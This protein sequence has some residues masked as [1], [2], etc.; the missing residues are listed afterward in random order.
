[1]KQRNFLSI[2]QILDMYAAILSLE[3]S[4]EHL[5]SYLMLTVSMK[6]S[7]QFLHFN[8]FLF[9]LVLRRD[10][11]DSLSSSLL[12]VDDRNLSP[13]SISWIGKIQQPVTV[14]HAMITLAGYRA[15][16]LLFPSG[17]FRVAV[18]WVVENATDVEKDIIGGGILFQQRRISRICIRN[19]FFLT[20][21]SVWH[22]VRNWNADIWMPSSSYSDNNILTEILNNSIEFCNV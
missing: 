2:Y 13:L 15:L 8:L 22:Q 12:S 21:S 16:C 19:S 17:S 1:M 9:F 18:T 20:C 11:W 5:V 4:R 6:T 7:I 14:F 3:L 10:G